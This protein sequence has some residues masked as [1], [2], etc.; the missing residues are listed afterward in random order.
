MAGEWDVV[1]NGVGDLCAFSAYL[2]GHMSTDPVC[3][4]KV[5]TAAAEAR[6]ETFD[7]TIVSRGEDVNKRFGGSEKPSDTTTNT[8]STLFIIKF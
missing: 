1:K 2:T 4:M 7:T 6:P 5:S 3:G 8:S